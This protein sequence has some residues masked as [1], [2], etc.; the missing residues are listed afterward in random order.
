MK[1][2]ILAITGGIAFA[3]TIIAF[4][5]GAGLGF[6]RGRELAVEQSDLDVHLADA[7]AWRDEGRT[8]LQ[9]IR[10]NTDEILSRQRRLTD[11]TPGEHV[12]YGGR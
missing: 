8:E 7:K 3:V 1:P 6:Q 4:F 11:F 5:V 12:H 9:A 10:A 2:I